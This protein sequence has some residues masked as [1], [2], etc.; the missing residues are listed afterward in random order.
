ML[1]MALRTIKSSWI[2]SI[3]K[4]SPIIYISVITISCL[5]IIGQW[6]YQ[7]DTNTQIITTWTILSW[8]SDIKP[9]ISTSLLDWKV[10]NTMTAE[11][12]IT[13]NTDTS[14]TYSH[15]LTTTDNIKYRLITDTIP[16]PTTDNIIQLTWTI[17]AIINSIPVI[18]VQ[19]ITTISTW[20][21]RAKPENMYIDKRWL[22]ID[23][24]AS[25]WS[26]ATIS[27]DTIIVQTS[28]WTATIIPFLCNKSS[29]QT[30]CWQ[31]INDLNKPETQSFAGSNSQ[32][33]YQIW[34]SQEFITIHT[35]LLWWYRIIVPDDKTL[36]ELSSVMTI[37]DKQFISNMLWTELKRSCN[38]LWTV[39]DISN[40]VLS[41]SN[42]TDPI[43]TIQAMTQQNQAIECTARLSLGK[44]IPFMILQ[45]KLS[46]Q[47]DQITERKSDTTPANPLHYRTSHGYNLIRPSNIITT[48]G[49]MSRQNF[50]I[51]WLR[52]STQIGLFPTS[53]P[54]TWN[55][56]ID[57]FLCTSQR[58]ARQLQN[59]QT[60]T[61][62]NLSTGEN[63]IYI[64]INDIDW[65]TFWRSITI[66]SQL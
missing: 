18:Q 24:A 66:E 9:V 17:S 52:C 58:P 43:I 45:V 15:M 20:I 30:N 26:K 50:G 61:M 22:I 35:E 7:T 3:S 32:L 63:H 33:F 47:Q 62:I 8:W 2:S 46:T 53:Q 41:A 25:P 42:A 5:V 16:V 54:D 1:S 13:T 34:S 23:T 10:W 29:K 31:I 28:A 48:R 38:R 55:S 57:I 21:F 65:T 14:S 59:D 56:V 12:I 19:K 64:R 40:L 37:I 6:I 49:R 4:I 44:T 36:I 11:W 51:I 27:W 39:K 60:S